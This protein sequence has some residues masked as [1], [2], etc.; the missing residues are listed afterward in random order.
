MRQTVVCKSEMADEKFFGMKD[1]KNCVSSAYS[2][3]EMV[4]ELKRELRVMYRLK[5]M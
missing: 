4:E 2:K 3:C 1:I 5:I